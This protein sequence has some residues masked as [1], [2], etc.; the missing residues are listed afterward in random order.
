MSFEFDALLFDLDGTLIA[1]IA[2]VDRCWSAWSERHGLDP[3]EVLPHIHGR[4]SID[5][6]RAIAP[7]LDAE[8]EDAWMRRREATDTAGVEALAGVAEFL[9]KLECPWA[10]VTSGTSDVALARVRAAGLPQPTVAVYGED[11][12]QGKPHPEPFLTAAERLGVAAGRCLA[13]EDAA[14]GIRSARAA[15]MRVIGVA[16]STR[17]GELAA[18]DAV[19]TDFRDLVLGPGNR[20]TV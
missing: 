18:A 2:A 3:A 12:S 9:A 5:S 20:V 19:I 16:A 17:T 15:G 8:Q 1:S 6:V 13:F 11:V 14:S 4:R 7:H 10:I